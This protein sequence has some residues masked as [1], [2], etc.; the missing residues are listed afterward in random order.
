MPCAC[1]YASLENVL[2][3]KKK[4][5]IK[6]TRLRGGGAIGGLHL[7]HSSTK[8]KKKKGLKFTLFS[9]FFSQLN[10]IILFLDTSTWFLPSFCFN[11]FFF[12]FYLGKVGWPGDTWNAPISSSL[13]SHTCWSGQSIV[14]HPLESSKRATKEDFKYLLAFFVVVVVLWLVRLVGT[15][16]GSSRISVSKKKRDKLRIYLWEGTYRKEEASFT[17]SYVYRSG[18]FFLYFWKR[19]EKQQEKKRIPTRP[20]LIYCL[21]IG[22]YRCISEALSYLKWK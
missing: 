1:V 4:K 19:N 11:I 21:C 12:Y 16:L 22:R 5:K 2:H 18:P 17:C 7:L 6:A 8:E 9:L 3:Q 13:F 20:A 15:F 14:A 10:D